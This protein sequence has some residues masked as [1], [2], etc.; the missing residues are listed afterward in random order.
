MGAVEE[1]PGDRVNVLEQEVWISYNRTFSCLR[2]VRYLG[3][4]DSLVKFC[5]NATANH[6]AT[7]SGTSIGGSSCS[8]RATSIKSPND[9]F[10]SGGDTSSNCQILDYVGKYCALV[11]FS[12]LGIFLSLVQDQVSEYVLVR[13]KNVSS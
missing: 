11:D 1:N 6:I 9:L 2:A 13:S 4:V 7:G 5:V 3:F 12:D 10:H 8:G